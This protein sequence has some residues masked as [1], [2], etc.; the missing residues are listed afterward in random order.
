M[1]QQ[2][3]HI[4]NCYWLTSVDFYLLHS[5][6]FMS[7]NVVIFSVWKSIGKNCKINWLRIELVIGNFSS[8]LSCVWLSISMVDASWLTENCDRTA[9]VAGANQKVLH[10]T[11]WCWS[12]R[13][14]LAVS[15]CTS[16]LRTATLSLVGLLGVTDNDKHF[17]LD[18]GTHRRWNAHTDSSNYYRTCHV[19]PIGIL[20]SF[21][22][23]I[24]S[25]LKKF[26]F[27]FFLTFSAFLVFPN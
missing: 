6:F 2:Y 23:Q 7:I 16:S 17:Y 10:G 20:C 14:V 13:S 1:Y 27:L 22:L 18:G 24:A 5:S 3:Q 26:D 21:I 8:E 4:K 15:L 11:A 9:A 25:M 12:A 19:L